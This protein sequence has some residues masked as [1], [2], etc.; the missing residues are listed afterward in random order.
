M[1]E[2]RT[3]FFRDPVHDGAADPT[4]IFNEQEKQWWMVYTNR[5]ADAPG[6]G[7]SWVHGTDLGAASSK[8]GVHWTY[9]GVLQGLAVEPGRN[10]FWAPEIIRHEGIYH[11]YVS[12]IQGVPDEWAGHLRQILHYTSANLWDWTYQSTLELSSEKVIDAA[13][14]TL[15]DGRFRMWYKDEVNHS[16]TYAADST[17]L[18][19]WKVVGPV[20]TEFPHEGAN[21]FVWKESYWLI[22][23]SWAGQVMYKSEDGEAWEK[24]TTILTENGVLEDDQGPGLHADVLVHEG[25]AIIYYFTHPSWRRGLSQNT[26]ET[27]RSSILAA[28]LVL[29]HGK[30]TCPRQTNIRVLT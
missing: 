4:I 2:E 21:V 5:R 23:D 20:I 25:R 19:S 29:T 1:S 26:Y 18:Y 22:V 16:H 9:R 17:D 28:E 15:P 27:R 11:M 13:I 6:A 3:A 24:Q 10:T 7:V 12:Y 30:L 14:A 8:D